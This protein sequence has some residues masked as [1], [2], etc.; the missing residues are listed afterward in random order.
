[1]ICYGRNNFYPTSYEHVFARTRCQLVYHHE[2]SSIYTF[3]VRLLRVDS[4]TVNHVL[5]KIEH[6]VMEGGVT[7]LF[8]RTYV[9]LTSDVIKCN[10]TARS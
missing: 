4:R 5:C 1:M 3:I 2:E 10:A 7:N 8:G 9:S 6:S